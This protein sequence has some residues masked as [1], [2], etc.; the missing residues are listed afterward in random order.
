MPAPMHV[1]PSSRSAGMA[2]G[3]RT[4]RWAAGGAVTSAPVFMLAVALVVMLLLALVVALELMLALDDK[5]GLPAT[6]ESDLLDSAPPFWPSPPSAAPLGFEGRSSMSNAI[7]KLRSRARNS[8][9]AST[10]RQPS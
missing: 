8:D 7:S 1:R 9:S 2:T 6:F 5:A 4:H 10:N 3:A